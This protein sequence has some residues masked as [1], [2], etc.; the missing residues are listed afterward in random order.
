VTANADKNPLTHFGRQVR[1]ERM[2]H[3]WSLRE[4][5]NITDLAAPY[6]SQIENG[7]RP[8]TLKVAQACDAAFPQR[9]GYFT[10]YYEESRTW[11]PAGFRDWTEHEEKTSTLRDWSP[12]VVT[13]LLQ[14]ADYARSVLE[15]SLGADDEII[16]KRLTT[17]MERQRR[18]FAR[19]LRAWFIIDEPSLSRLAGSP[20]VMAEQMSH[21]LD[22]ADQP[23]I[24]VQVLPAV[25]HP[26]GA[27]GFVI[28]DTAAYAEH[29]IAG[30]VYTEA[31]TVTRFD[32]VFDTLRAECHRA[33]ESAAI[34]RRVGETWTGEQV[35]TA[36]PTAGTA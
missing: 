7:R 28:T 32:I 24:T 25:I 29:V 13:G 26:A 6:W 17:R 30:Y 8:P 10:E 3:G 18:L 11:M 31:E 5:A 22:V 33:S 23:N 4:F 9:N 2:A 27:G 34:I 15:T 20:Q 16:T 12:T 1:K 14:T 36:T 35:P 21:L 19:E